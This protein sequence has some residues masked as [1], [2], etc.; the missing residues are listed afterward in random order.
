MEYKDYYNVMSLER[1]ATPDQIKTAYRKLARK[2]H[3]DVSKEKDAEA[4]FKELGEAYAVLSDEQKRAQYDQLG[5][6]W[7]SGEQFTPPPGW[8]SYSSADGQG[9][10]GAGAADFSDF[11]ESLFGGGFRQ[12]RHANREYSQRGEDLQSKILISLEDA[13]HGGTHAIQVNGRTLNIK[14]PAGVTQGQHIRLAG[15]GGPGI[16]KGANGDLYLEIDLQ[17]HPL[18]KIDKKNIYLSLPITPW[19]AAL[20]ATVAV[21]TLGGKVELKIPAGSQ[22]GQKLRLRGRGLPGGD[23]YVVLEIHTPKAE[24]EAAKELYQQMEKTMPFNPRQNIGG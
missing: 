5:S 22:S 1:N 18:Y 7:Q 6:Q 16:G 8:Q 10:T 17:L 3:P 9:F 19:E 23:Q 21:P 11:F 12:Q 14:V 2:Y 4:K 15:Q 20:G 24:T 13:Y